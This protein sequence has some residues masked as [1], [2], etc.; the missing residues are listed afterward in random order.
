VVPLVYKGLDWNSSAHGTHSSMSWRTWTH[1]HTCITYIYV[2]ASNV[3]LL[4]QVITMD[5]TVCRIWPYISV[6]LLHIFCFWSVAWSRAGWVLHSSS[7]MLFY[8]ICRQTMNHLKQLIKSC[9][10]L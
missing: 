3:G 5:F 4:L 1:T 8:M 2:A 6:V 9:S 10:V 7:Q